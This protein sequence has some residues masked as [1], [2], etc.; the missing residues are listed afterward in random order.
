MLD[1]LRGIGAL[2]VIYGHYHF[3]LWPD[4]GGLITS[5]RGYLV[6]D[7]FFLLS[8]FVLAYA[9]YD[10]PSFDIWE[11][12][13]KRAFRLW[14]LHLASLFCFVLVMYLS[15][16]AINELGLL[17]NVL[18]LHNAGFGDW[19]TNAF[20]YPSWSLSVELIVN[21]ALAVVILAIPNRRWNTLLLAALGLISAAILFFTVDSLNKQVSNVFGFLNIGLLRGFITMPMGILAY[22][23][24]AAH[25]DWFERESRLRTLGVGVLLL[26]FVATLSLPSPYKTDFLYLP[27]YGAV[28]LL[29]ASPGTFWTG[30]ARQFRFLGEISFAMYIGHMIV[31]KIMK[32]TGFW[33]QDYVPGLLFAW[34]LSILLAIVAHHAIEKPAYDWLT[35][36]WC[37]SPA[38]TANAAYQPAET[39]SAPALAKEKSL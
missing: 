31:L 22:R 16:D 4:R 33:P 11:F 29:L 28:I 15:G 18:L 5:S 27:L 30:I 1:A 23:I 13:K 24:F 17:L 10:R 36:R 38:P 34:G 2:L 25:R 21:L 26:L 14:P 35:R 37:K 12:T 3:E 39:R 6:V 7:V 20:N 8:G 19:H 32:E 9:F